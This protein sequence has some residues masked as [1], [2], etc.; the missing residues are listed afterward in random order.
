MLFAGQ[1]AQILATLAVVLSGAIAPAVRW[2]VHFGMGQVPAVPNPVFVL[3]LLLAE[4]SGTIALRTVELAVRRLRYLSK[5]DAKVEVLRLG[6]AG[7]LGSHAKPGG[8]FG[9]M[10]RCHR[11]STKLT[12]FLKFW[13]NL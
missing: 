5:T 6:T 3:G 10:R 12:G 8:V 4:L 1:K 2:L 11:T 9:P 7:R 13:N